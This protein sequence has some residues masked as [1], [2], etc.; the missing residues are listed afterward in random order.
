MRPLLTILR[1]LLL[2]IMSLASLITVEIEQAQPA[3]LVTP[4]RSNELYAAKAI[5]GV[6]LALVQAARPCYSWA[7]WAAGRQPVI[8][9]VT[10]LSG[11]C[12]W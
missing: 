4:M 3:L 1:V 5:L 12:L 6:G 9:L 8:I 11:A 10:F 2:E 7:W